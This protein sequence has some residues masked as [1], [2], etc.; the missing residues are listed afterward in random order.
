MKDRSKIIILSVLLA[1]ICLLFLAPG[2]T[3]ENYQYFLSQRMPKVFAIVL[4]GSAI[5]FSS[6]LFQTITVNRILTPTALGL[7]ALYLMT[8]TL[9]VFFF[10]SAS[11]LVINKNLNFLL[12]TAVMVLLSAL[13]FR[14]MLKRDDANLIRLILVGTIFGQLFRSFTYFLLM[15]INPN[16]FVAL[17]NKMFAS[18]NSI[19]TGVLALTAVIFLIISLFIYGDLHRYDVI[20]LGREQAVGLGIDHDRFVRKSFLIISV[21]ISVAT[22]LVG[23]IT[24]LG[25]LIANIA[26][27]TAKTYK[28]SVILILSILLGA[29]FL[30]GGQL[31]IEQFLNFDTTVSV[32]INFIGGIYFI[33]LLV[34]ESKL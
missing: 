2:L 9:I 23:P 5:A 13:L 25:L 29:L 3:I 7:D 12:S 30:L 26:R 14:L 15:I 20:A 18:F 34:R 24:F 16:E 28:H 32:I 33:V 8:Q 21:L 6:V 31:L 10:G 4:T 17:Q 11:L 1:A 22:A 19:N 27:Q